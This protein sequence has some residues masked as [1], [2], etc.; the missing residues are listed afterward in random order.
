MHT[1][2]DAYEH[3]G[4]LANMNTYTETSTS[5][6]TDAYIQDRLRQQA[7][8]AGRRTETNLFTARTGR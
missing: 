8:R 5:R 7:D 6:H 4:M 1:Q 2:L 3:R